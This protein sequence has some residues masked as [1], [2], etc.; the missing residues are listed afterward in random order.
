MVLRSGEKG[1]T[2]VTASHVIANATRILWRGKSIPFTVIANYPDRDIAFVLVKENLGINTKVR[3]QSVYPGMR[4]LALGFPSLG[5]EKLTL[6]V[7]EG[8]I[9][10][11]VRKRGQPWYRISASIYYGSSGGPIFDEDGALVCVASHMRQLY[12]IPIQDNFYC[13]PVVP[14]K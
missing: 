2:L 10:S 9:A 6:S 5:A 8:V 1:S 7:T 14:D 4:I 11:V 12:R 13:A 3:Y